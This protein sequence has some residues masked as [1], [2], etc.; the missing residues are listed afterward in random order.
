M[1]PNFEAIQKE[2]KTLSTSHNHLQK[3]YSNLKDYSNKLVVF[4]NEAKRE[5]KALQGKYDNLEKNYQTEYKGRAMD[6]V[7]FLVVLF[8]VVLIFVIVGFFV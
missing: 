3:E 4:L 7:K 8:L 1:N 6:K 5:K 2:F